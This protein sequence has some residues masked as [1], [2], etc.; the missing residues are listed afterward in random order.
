[1]KKVVKKKPLSFKDILF[2]GKKLVNKSVKHK[3][4]IKNGKH[5]FFNGQRRL[6]PQRK[7]KSYDTM[8]YKKWWNGLIEREIINMLKFEF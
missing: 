4:P 2:D 8:L 1:M 6:V 3:E 7:K 5:I